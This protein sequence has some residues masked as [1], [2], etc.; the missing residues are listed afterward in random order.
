[1]IEERYNDYINQENINY[2]DY[3][4]YLNK[5][6]IEF[7]SQTYCNGMDN[8]TEIIPI[9]DRFKPQHFKFIY[10]LEE[11]FCTLKHLACVVDDRSRRLAN[12][13]N[14]WVKNQGDKRKI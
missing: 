3:I 9:D 7:R 5:Q 1:M 8:F 4:E 6:G 10:I 14:R 2:S 11:Y 12:Y 13:S